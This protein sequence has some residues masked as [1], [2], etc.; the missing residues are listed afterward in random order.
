[1]ESPFFLKLKPGRRLEAIY[2]LGWLGIF[3]LMLALVFSMSLPAA[4]ILIHANAIWKS[5]GFN[6]AKMFRGI[7]DEPIGIKS[8]HIKALTKTKMYT[9]G[10][11]ENDT[12]SAFSGHQKKGM[13]LGLSQ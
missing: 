7:G 12:L 8:T 13:R 6:A 2:G 9:N 11:Y 4:N 5:H 1:M 10:R 3:Y